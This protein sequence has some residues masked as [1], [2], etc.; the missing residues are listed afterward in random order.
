MKKYGF[1]KYLYI[2][3]EDKDLIDVSKVFLFDIEKN[4]IIFKEEYKKNFSNL[5]KYMNITNFIFEPEKLSKKSPLTI[6]NAPWGT[7]K[8]FF[9]ENFIKLFIDKKIKSNI[10]KKIIIIDAWKFS[11]SKDIPFEFAIELSNKIVNMHINNESEETK[12]AIV[13]K[14][15]DWIIPDSLK[16]QLKFF[17]FITLEGKHTNKNL[18]ENKENIKTLWKKI[19]ENNEPTIIFIDNLE[20]LGSSSWDLLK[21]ILKI[22]EFDNYLITLPLN[23]N[24]FNNNKRIDN[25][26]Y[27]IEKYIDFNYY[28]LQQDYSN[29]FNKHF[30][31]EQKFIEKLNLIFDSEI[32]GEKLS[33]REVENSFRTH[34]LFKTKDEYEILKIIE[35][36]IWYPQEIFNIFLRNDTKYFLETEGKKCNLFLEIASKISEKDTRENFINISKKDL[37]NKNNIFSWLNNERFLY[38]TNFDYLHEYSNLLDMINYKKSENLN[39]IKKTNKIINDIKQLIEKYN[40]NI[41]KLNDEKLELENLE[42]IEGNIVENYDSEKHIH[43]QQRIKLVTNKIEEINSKIQELEKNNM[44]N[45]HDL[46]FLNENNNKIFDISIKIKELE[47]INKNDKLSNKQKQQILLILKNNFETIDEKIENNYNFDLNNVSL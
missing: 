32:D 14:I 35:K 43:L 15:L 46:I 29:F 38:K 37:N 8:T 3:L 11:N 17:N 12:H 19:K 23:L 47:N 9:I 6:I 44:I 40:K 28:N 20:R 39:Q 21:A 34:N 25:S 22:Q 30:K 10:F 42:N 1:I 27:P 33:I 16:W 24:K 5:Q 26:E 41:I 45:N 2:K 7:G 31:K 36:N 13:Q 18:N 4:F